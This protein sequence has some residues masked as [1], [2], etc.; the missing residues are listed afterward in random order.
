M[1][2]IPTA[3]ESPS[4]IPTATLL[5][6]PTASVTPI[7]TATPDINQEWLT[8]SPVIFNDFCSIKYF[9][10]LFEIEDNDSYSESNGLLRSSVTYEGY[11]DDLKDY[12][13]FYLCDTKDVEIRLT[14]YT[15]VGGQLQLFYQTTSNRLA[16]VTSPPFSISRLNADPGMYYV[17]INTPNGQNTTTKYQLIVEYP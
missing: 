7:N 14:N 9:P 2:P 16:Y 15:G 10:Q 5:P 11:P 12:F 4:P 3:T 6:S 13:S 1:T 8:F 17:Y